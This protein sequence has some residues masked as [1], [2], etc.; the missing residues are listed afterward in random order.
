[1]QRRSLAVHRTI[2]VVDIEGFGDRRRTDLDQVAVRNGLYKVMQDAFYHAGIPWVDDGHEDRGDGVFVLVSGDIPKSLFVESLPSALVSALREHNISHSQEERIRLRMALHA[3]E[4]NYD[5]HGATATSIILAFRLLE[6]KQLKASL[7]NSTG[8]LA[9]IISSR[10]YE[11]VVRNNVADADVYRRVLVHVKETSAVGWIYPPDRIIPTSEPTIKGASDIARSPLARLHLAYT[12]ALSKPITLADELGGLQIPTLRDGYIDHR[13]R[14]SKQGVSSEPAHESW[15][16]NIPVR[17]SSLDFFSRYLSSSEALEEPLLLLGHPGSGKSVLTRILAA[18]LSVGDFL[19]L[20][21]EL[22]QVPAEL[23]LQGQIEFAVRNTIGESISWSQLVKSGGGA[24][25][26]VM[27]DGFDE[28]LQTTGASQTGFLVRVR[29]FQERE[30]VQGRSLAVIVTSRT[31]VADR[32]RIPQSTSVARLEPFSDDQVAAWLKVWNRYNQKQLKER[33][34]LPLPA[35][36]ALSHKELAEQPLLL[37]MLALYDAETN[38][39]QKKRAELSRTELYGRL[40]KE[41]ARREV[42][43]HAEILPEPDIEL[44]A[45]A[46]LR[47][48]SV[49]AFAIFNRRSQWVSESDLDRDLSVLLGENG[50]VPNREGTP[51][52]LTAAQVAISRFFFIHTAQATHDGHQLQTYE[53][54]HATFGEFLVARLVTQ[55]LSEIL[56]EQKTAARSPKSE[57][58]DEL[59]YSLLSFA[60]LTASNPVITFLGDLISELEIGQRE[61]LTDALLRMHARSLYYR[62][63]ST[64]SRYE[65]LSLTAT[66]RCAAW[67]ANLVVLAVLVA[68]KIT[69]AQLFPHEQESGL[70][71]RNHALIWRSQL[72]GRGWEGLYETIA[73]KRIWDGHRREI[74]LWRNDG[75]FTPPPVDVHW[76]YTLYSAWVAQTRSCGA[77]KNIL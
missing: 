58:S 69:S 15:W 14:I 3:G 7:A 36:I 56:A 12:N 54:L 5:D 22:R 25:P 29:N 42:S 45:E 75:T 44:E 52:Q 28:L 1:M 47:R 10:F 63:E 19:P 35:P 9:F 64:Y 11:E 57:P 76:I 53:F 51:A 27:L 33:K 21:V 37:L 72:A 13:I 46:E 6:A 32:A 24:L 38:I 2:V 65:P 40:L 61:A 4:V 39:L 8:L 31:A 55:L 60:A 26:V 50:K 16:D 41:F 49:V 77:Q 17:D 34:M 67:S 48:L 30:A 20:R 70:A 59:M 73:L 62:P 66:T 74:L 43:K 18:R 23:D 71:W 68:G